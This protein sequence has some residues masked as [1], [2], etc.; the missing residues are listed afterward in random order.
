[1]GSK[2]FHY[3]RSSNSGK[4]DWRIS[5]CRQGLLE[6]ADCLGPRVTNL[7]SETLGNVDDKCLYKVSMDLGR[8]ITGRQRIGIS[9]NTREY[10]LETKIGQRVQGGRQT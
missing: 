4:M 8:I 5:T 2:R 10:P 7:E 3:F 9:K 1:M 6:K